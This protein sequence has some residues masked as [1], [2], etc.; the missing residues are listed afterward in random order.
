MKKFAHNTK[1]S[2]LLKSY[3]NNYL[4]SFSTFAH[5]KTKTKIFFIVDLSIFD[6]KE[7][8]K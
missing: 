2:S 4:S 5:L 1:L 7:K 6:K 3:L 8:P